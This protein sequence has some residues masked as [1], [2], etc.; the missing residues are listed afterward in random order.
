MARHAHGV[1]ANSRATADAL[2]GYLAA[3]GEPEPPLS[4]NPL[5][6]TRFEPDTPPIDDPYFLCLGTIEPRKNHL[7][8]LHLWRQFADRA[9]G[10]PVPR[11]VLVGRR[12]WENQNTFNLLDR[13]PQLRPHVLELGR[14][15]DRA[16]AAWLGGASALLMPSFAEGFGLPVAEALA[17]DGGRRVVRIS[18]QRAVPGGISS[19]G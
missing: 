13:C 12:G 16:L 2:A 9:D 5:G 17:A 18:S 14:V 15:S 11:L 6:V 8:L 19:A 4:V 10:R 1:I 7:L 3:S